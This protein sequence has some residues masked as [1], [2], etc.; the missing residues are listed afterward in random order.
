[1]I[2]NLFTAPAFFDDSSSGPVGS[3]ATS[4]ASKEAKDKELQQLRE[5]TVVMNDNGKSCP[6]C[7]EPFVKF[8]SDAEEDWLFRNAVE[9]EGVVCNFVTI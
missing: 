8:Y 6:I 1:M 7:G 4:T 9:V 2:S 3:G 5:S